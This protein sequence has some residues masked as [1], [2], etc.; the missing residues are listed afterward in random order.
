VTKSWNIE[1]ENLK[2]CPHVARGKF[3]VQQMVAREC[4]KKCHMNKFDISLTMHIL[5]LY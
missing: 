4:V 3:F 5:H 1:K 2:P